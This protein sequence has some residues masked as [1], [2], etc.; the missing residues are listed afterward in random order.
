MIHMRDD[1]P[2]EAMPPWRRFILA[3]PPYRCDVAESF[4]AARTPRSQYDF[5]NT[6]EAGQGLI[7]SLGHDAQTIA[8]DTD[9]AEDVGIDSQEK[10]HE[11]RQA[12][13]SSKAQNRALLVR[14]ETL[15]THMSR[16]EWQRQRVE[17]DAVRQIMRIHVL[18]TRAQ[19]D[20]VEDTD[21]SC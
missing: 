15:E 16:M 20:T 21:N 14:H 17:D 19:I 2:E 13:L 8:R 5:V 4:V 1:I 7:H 18:E 11:V 6:V 12:Y 9:G 3:A 10:L